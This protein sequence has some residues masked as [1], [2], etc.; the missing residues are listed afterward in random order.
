MK[1]ILHIIKYKLLVFL[2]L[3]SEISFGYLVKATSSSLVY[4]LFA[5]GC[6]F[7]TTNSMEY[8]LSGI[9]I[10][11]FLFH[12]FISVILFIFF[13]TINIG[14]IVVSYSTLYKSKEIY[15]FI[16]KPISFTKIFIIKFLDN[17][18]YSSSTLL[19]IVGAIILGYGIYFNLDWY[20]YPIS[21]IGIILPFMFTAGS[22]GAIILLIVLKL[23]SKIGIKK[24]LTTIGLIYAAS[25]LSYYFLSSPAETVQKVFE[26]YP[27]IDAYFGFLDNN[28]LKLLPNYWVSDSLFWISNG[29]YERAFPFMYVNILSSI[30]MFLIAVFLAHKWYYKT[31]S[32]YSISNSTFRLKSNNKRESI[33]NL[34]SSLLNGINESILKREILLFFR[35]PN[36]W[37]HLIVM[38]FLI[39]IFITSISGIDMTILNA[40]NDY[41]RTAIYIAVTIFNVFLISSISIR[42][43][44]PLISLEGET[45]WKLRTAPVDLKNLIF[46]KLSIYFLIVFILGQIISY[47]SNF[48]FPVELAIIAQLNMA[49]ITIAL[50]SLNFGMGGIFLNLKERNAIRIASSQGAS[51]TLLLSLMFLILIVVILFVPVFNFF[52]E[53]KNGYQIS[54]INLLTSTMILFI[55]ASLSSY[56]FLKAGFKSLQRD[57]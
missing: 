54:K 53:I 16:S 13:I 50:V 52:Q 26:Y 39:V 57:I 43:I 24:V 40:Y 34:K 46:K 30:A 32:E 25:V 18:F 23:S 56:F 5:Y 44:F 51:I 48:H 42:F 27:N 12:R 6:Y 41:F 29:S 17:F 1:S 47:F 7:F 3:N 38:L 14:N 37:I 9:N 21:L 4:G 2:K 22:L 31:W 15:F 45:F 11:M 49:I 20:F 36:Q 55:I 33:F 19:L 28:F 8:L 10:G 35:E